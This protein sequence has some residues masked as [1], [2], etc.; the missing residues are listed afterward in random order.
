MKPWL[1]PLLTLFVALVL[2][3]AALLFADSAQSVSGYSGPLKAKAELDRG[4]ACCPPQP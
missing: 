2:L 3:P 4:F 1:F